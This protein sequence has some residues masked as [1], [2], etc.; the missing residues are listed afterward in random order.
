MKLWL[1]LYLFSNWICDT[2]N[3]WQEDFISEILYRIHYVVSLNKK[4]I[5]QKVFVKVNK[6]LNEANDANPRTFIVKHSKYL[7]RASVCKYDSVCAW[8]GIYKEIFISNHRMEI[9]TST[10]E[11][12]PEFDP[13]PVF[14][15]IMICRGKYLQWI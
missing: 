5:K 2:W 8:S 1:F 4:R 12:S 9:A 3:W 10:E 15:L 13:K 6:Q 14:V 11:S 7:P